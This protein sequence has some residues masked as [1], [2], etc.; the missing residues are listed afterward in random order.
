MTKRN[1]SVF[2]QTLV[3]CIVLSYIAVSLTKWALGRYAT[4]SASYAN[5]NSY[6]KS[7]ALAGTYIS[8]MNPA[9]SSIPCASSQNIQ[10]ESSGDI[11]KYSFTMDNVSG[12]SVTDAGTDTDGGIISAITD[13]HGGITDHGFIQIN[14]P[15]TPN[16]G[17]GTG[18]GHGGG[19][20]TPN[21]GIGGGIRPADPVIGGGTTI[22][23]IGGNTNLQPVADIR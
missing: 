15:L 21:P 17:I 10:C 11:N 18:T 4:S 8:L 9:S 19:T 1:G 12:L 7:S 16:T 14:G 23:P 3:I 13:L 5:A 2:L 6:M 20:V 22:R